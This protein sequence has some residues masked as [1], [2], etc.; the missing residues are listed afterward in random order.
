[1]I[2]ATTNLQPNIEKL[3]SNI[4]P[5]KSHYIEHNAQIKKPFMCCMC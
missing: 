5:Q 4:Q 3:A 1:M 2:L